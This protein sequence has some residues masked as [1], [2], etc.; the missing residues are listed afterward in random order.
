MIDS[1][2]YIKSLN[3]TETGESNTNDSYILIPKMFNASDFFGLTTGNKMYF[4]IL[5][6][7]EGIT[8]NLRYEVTSNTKEQRIYML[9]VFCRKKHLHA[10]DTISIE[11]LVIDG[12][13]SF[14]IR[15]KRMTNIVLLK[16][17]KGD[18]LIER[19]DIGNSILQQSLNLSYFGRTINLTL[20]FKHHGKKRNDSPDKLIF[21]EA[22]VENGQNL[23]DIIRDQYIILDFNQKAIVKFEKTTEYRITQ[24]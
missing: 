18:Y 12:Q 2:I 1:R 10:G 11:H 7:E 13:S 9:G 19:N 8:Y 22:T 5:D 6:P 4:N 3:A 14:I 16:K 15:Y 24:E 20:S 21:Y 23:S 17:L